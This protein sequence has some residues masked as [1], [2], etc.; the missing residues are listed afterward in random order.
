MHHRAGRRG[1]GIQDSE[2]IVRQHKRLSS[3]KPLVFLA[4]SDYSPRQHYGF[5]N[6]RVP[7]FIDNMPR[8]TAAISLPGLA[9]PSICARDSE[10]T[11][12]SET[13]FHS[14]ILARASNQVL[15]HYSPIPGYGAISTLS[16]K[17]WQSTPAMSTANTRLCFLQWQIPS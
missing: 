10:K 15:S 8:S 17:H 2:Q 9:S 3:L 6:R 14:A 13:R 12:Y 11:Q 4:G 1:L 5:H 7:C 16:E